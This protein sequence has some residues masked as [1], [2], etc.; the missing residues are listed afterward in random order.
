MQ[1]EADSCTLHD[2]GSQDGVAFLV[3]EYLEG[4]TLAERLKK[5]ALPLDQALEYGIQ[6]AD[7]LDKAHRQGIVHR[8]LKPGN[9]MLTKSG[10]SLLDF[11]LAKL[12][13]SEGENAEGL[14]SLPTEAKSLT[15]EGAILGTVQ[16]MAPEQLE[17]KE[18]DSRTDIFAFG[19][20]LYEMVTGKRAF[21]GKSG[22]S[23]AGAIL[24]D[25]VPTVSPPVL[26]HLVQT[27]V[28]KDPD[29]RWQSASDVARQLE[30][31]NKQSTQ[32][33]ELEPTRRSPALLGAMLLLGEFLVDSRFGISARARR[34]RHVR[35]WSSK[36]RSQTPIASSPMG[37]HSR[38]TARR[39]STS[40]GATKRI[41]SSG[42]IST[43][44]I[45][46]RST[47][48]RTLSHRFSHEMGSG[49]V[50][51]PKQSCRKS[52]SREVHQKYFAVSSRRL[53]GGTWID[54]DT[55][56][57]GSLNSG[58]QRVSASG[59]DPEALTFLED[60]EA[61]HG[62]PTCL[63]DR[64]A[65]LFTSVP[66]AEES[67]RWIVME[68]L[69]S[70]ERR[71][72]VRGEAARFLGSGRLVFARENSLWSAPFD[73]DSPELLGEAV[74]VRD[75]VGRG[76]QVSHF[77]IANN[78]TLAY[79]P[80]GAT[81]FRDELVEMSREGAR[82]R[83][84]DLPGSSGNPAFS[85]DGSQLAATVT[86]PRT[87][88]D[89]WLYDLES[90][91]SRRF[92]T[93]PASEGTVAWAHDGTRVFF[94]SSRLGSHDI[95]V[96]SVGG[97]AEPTVLWQSD[98]LKHVMSASADGRFLVIDVHEGGEE[99]DLWIFPLTGDGSP[100]PVVDT[101]F[102]EDDGAISPD[103]RWFAYAS[104]QSGH[105]EIYVIPFQRQGQ[106]I[107]V[108]LDGAKQPRWRGDGRELF[109]IAL[110]G[111]LMAVAFDD[112]EVGLPEPLFDTGISNPERSSLRWDVSAD[113]QRFIVGVPAGD[114]ATRRIR[115]V[116]DWASRLE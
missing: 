19:A 79:S 53:I 111:T 61:S 91:R 57:F 52:R 45:R 34:R 106:P 6:I 20:V 108:S 5:G 65:V 99:Q 48:P 43:E 36:S 90:G 39:S 44:S 3:M 60:G 40:P 63:A 22:A 93:H 47:G 17:G 78:G 24:K 15:A 25:E 1:F 55:I 70:G 69:G 37:L 73:P 32:Q 74:P 81:A 68:W 8:D 75:D 95:F 42:A 28:A 100:E 59:G 10:A 89:V 58:L 54:A 56:V 96:K 14:S 67:E 38:P 11:G 94:R 115:V 4:Q 85:P 77:A 87:G 114:S 46:C 92:T 86:T 82:L 71:R 7:A 31:I 29:E 30:W 16:Y 104:T 84:L 13:A 2:V 109:Y 103:G 97:N 101:D 64:Q 23:L 26:D 88:Q 9:I 116:L 72:L 18:A 35:D 21:E 83:T 12:A 50:S 51:S 41:S 49:S 62:W 76:N 107:Q 33:Q 66:R 27:C 112:G 105:Y 98:Q 110:N 80:G 102:D 113:G